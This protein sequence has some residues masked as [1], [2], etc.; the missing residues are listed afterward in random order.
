VLSIVRI[1]ALIRTIGLI[2]G[3]AAESGVNCF[4][5]RIVLALDVTTISRYFSE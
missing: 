3:L 5:D 2:V 4:I 1:T